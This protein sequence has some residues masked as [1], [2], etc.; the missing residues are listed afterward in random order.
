MS[1]SELASFAISGSAATV[2]STLII[3]QMSAPTPAASA[4]TATG[5]ATPTKTPQT[6]KTKKSAA[7]A[8]GF[9]FF[10]AYYVAATARLRLSSHY[11]NPESTPSTRWAASQAFFI[12]TTASVCTRLLGPGDSTSASSEKDALETQAP[13]R[14]KWSLAAL[15]DGIVLGLDPGLTFCI[16]EILARIVAKHQWRLQSAK[17]QQQQQQHRIN[18]L[19]AAA[20]TFILAAVSKAIAKGITHPL[21]TAATT[22]EVDRRRRWLVDET[23]ESDVNDGPSVLA[24]L[25][26]TL[27]HPGG[28]SAL[29]SGW[30]RAVAMA[31]LGHGLTMAFQRLL[32]GVVLQLVYRLR[33]ELSTRRGS[34][35]ERR[36][37]QEQQHIPPSSMQAQHGSAF[38]EVREA[39]R[40]VP[41]LAAKPSE[42][43]DMLLDDHE[44]VT[45]AVESWLESTAA[46]PKDN[47]DHSKNTDDAFQ[48]PPAPPPASSPRSVVSSQIRKEQ[49]WAENQPARQESALAPP[50]APSP[51]SAPSP[52]DGAL[53]RYEASRQTEAV[54]PQK[55]EAPVPE[56]ADDT[57]DETNNNV[58]FNMISKSPRM[59]RR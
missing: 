44:K 39:P 14:H 20:I 32:Y 7:A 11:D 5:T 24:T 1:L 56:A 10:F 13:P 54:V 12:G 15:E 42:P 50:S 34:G 6:P 4:A 33:R 29:Y 40:A 25:W 49:S 55:Q 19:Y 58:V 17:Q 45:K 41:Q 26:K 21:Y 3:N 43:A 31:S 52:N 51:S 59:V 9:V 28:I 35:R 36:E 38:A 48:L 30:L 47:F 8:N 37:L 57:G 46:P 2:V 23:G 53:V 16:H 18:G 27:R 22:A